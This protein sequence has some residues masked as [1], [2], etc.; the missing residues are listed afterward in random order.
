MEMKYKKKLE[1]GSSAYLLKLIDLFIRA[2]N[3]KLKE[4]KVC[5]APVINYCNNIGLLTTLIGSLL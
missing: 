2:T 5:Y 1:L 3:L 4:T